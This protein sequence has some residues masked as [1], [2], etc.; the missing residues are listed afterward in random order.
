VFC[1]FCQLTRVM[2]FYRL[3]FFIALYMR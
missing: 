1:Y 3:G 2:V